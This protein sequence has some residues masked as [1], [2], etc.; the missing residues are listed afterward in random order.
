[1]CCLPTTDNKHQDLSPE[2]SSPGSPGSPLPG[3]SSAGDYEPKGQLTIIKC[4]K[5]TDS[6]EEIKRV[7]QKFQ[8]RTNCFQYQQFSIKIV[9]GEMKADCEKC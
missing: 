1:M 8:I 4:A 9:A 5:I 7:Y 3:A 6:V 2:R